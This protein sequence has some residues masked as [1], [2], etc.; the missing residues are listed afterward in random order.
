[1]RL[2]EGVIGGLWW[3]DRSDAPP[4]DL[5]RPEDRKTPYGAPWGDQGVVGR[6]LFDTR[7]D[8]HENTRCVVYTQGTCPWGFSHVEIALF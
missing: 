4:T 7:E 6:S 2:E 1:M 8:V 5:G 3:E